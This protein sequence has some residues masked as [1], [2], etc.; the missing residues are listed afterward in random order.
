M[1][2][3]VPA[4]VAM[5]DELNSSGE[6]VAVGNT[7]FSLTPALRES[8]ATGGD[9]EL[10]YAAMLDAARASLRLLNAELAKDPKTAMRRAVVSADVDGALLRPDLDYAV[11]KLAGPIPMKVIAAIHLDTEDAQDAV[12]A[13]AAVV[14]AADLGDPDAEFTLGDAEDHELAWYAPQ[15]LPFLLELL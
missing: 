5:L 6:L 3:Y 1:R 9:E 12:R 10:E 15:E 7:A 11:V 8:Y 2:V 13:A 14:D 4:T